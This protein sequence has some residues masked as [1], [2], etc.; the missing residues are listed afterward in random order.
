MIVRIVPTSILHR[1]P[2]VLYYMAATTIVTLG[3]TELLDLANIA[4]VLT[5][6][7][8]Q[9]QAGLPDRLGVQ[10]IHRHDAPGQFRR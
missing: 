1:R 3:H 7:L 10:I 6:T 2:G 8:L 5:A 4:V 9:H